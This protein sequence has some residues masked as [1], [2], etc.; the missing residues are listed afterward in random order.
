ML[1][2]IALTRDISCEEICGI[3]GSLIN[4]YR[5]SQPDLSNSVMVIDIKNIVYSI[6]NEVPKIEMKQ[7]E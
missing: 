2:A 4:E 1:K 5:I 6:D 3:I 7:N